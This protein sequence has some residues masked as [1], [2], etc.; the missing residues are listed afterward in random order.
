MDGEAA[1]QQLWAQGRDKGQWFMLVRSP[2]ACLYERQRTV[3]A[4]GIGVKILEIGVEVCSWSECGNDE[5]IG[6]LFKI[7]QQSGKRLCYGDAHYT[8]A[9]I[10]E[11]TDQLATKEEL[12]LM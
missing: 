1:K 11:P 9:F 7:V 6:H 2:L 3:S 4:F 5:S 8:M 10:I 12:L